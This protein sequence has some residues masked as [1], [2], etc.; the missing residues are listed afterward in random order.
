MPFWQV[1]TQAEKQLQ[2]V[3]G[4]AGLCPLDRLRQQ[5]YDR[6]ETIDN[7]DRILSDDGRIDFPVQMDYIVEPVDSITPLWSIHGEEPF[8]VKL[9]VTERE[10]NVVSAALH[11]D[12]RKLSREKVERWADRFGSL[13]SN[14]EYGGHRISVATLIGRFYQKLW[15]SNG[16]TLNIAS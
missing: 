1:V 12:A 16:S 3:D 14:L 8:D 10:G 13:L 5:I 6:A 4:L 11:Y 7:V 15:A 2:L 9:V